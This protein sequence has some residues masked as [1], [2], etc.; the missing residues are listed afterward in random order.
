MTESSA[1]RNK[2]VLALTLANYFYS[3]NIVKSDLSA[4]ILL[5]PFKG[6]LQ[7][8]PVVKREQKSLL[9]ILLK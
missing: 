1:P 4:M 6:T 2:E 5:S 7:D 9:A 8:K 3:K